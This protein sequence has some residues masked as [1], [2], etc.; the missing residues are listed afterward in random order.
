MDH[1][2]IE[3]STFSRRVFSFSL[4]IA[5]VVRREVAQIA[6]EEAS[7]FSKNGRTHLSEWP[8]L[9]EKRDPH[10]RQSREQH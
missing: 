2:L 1:F 6:E 4:R 8:L 7:R 3:K 10:A 5:D 9:A